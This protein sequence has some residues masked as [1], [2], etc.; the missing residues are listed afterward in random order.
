MIRRLASVMALLLVATWSAPADGVVDCSAPALKEIRES[1]NQ[2]L[3]AARSIRSNALV[4]LLAANI[5]N[6]EAILA[7]K[8]RARNTTGMAVA[9]T[10]RSIFAGA[11]SNLSVT[12]KVDVPAKVRRELVPAVEEFKTAAQRIEDEFERAKSEI[13]QQHLARYQSLTG[14]AKPDA[15]GGLQDF[16]DWVGGKQ[17]TVPAESAGTPVPA[18]TAPPVMLATRGEARQWVTVGRWQGSVGTMDVIPVP[19]GSLQVGTNRQE[20]ANPIAQSVARVEYQG[21]HAIPADFPGPLRLKAVPGLE[22]V[23][24]VEWPAT[25]NDFT[26]SIRLAAASYPSKH[27]FDL[28]AG[29]PEGGAGV[30][31]AGAAMETTSGEAMAAAPVML[32]LNTLPEGASVMLDGIPVKEA[33]TPCHIAVPAGIHTVELAL[34][35]YQKLVLANQEFVTNRVMKLKFEPDPRVVSKSCEISAGVNQWYPSGLLV[36]P[37]SLLVIKAEG[38]WSCG[39]KGERC[40][41]SGYTTAVPTYRHY[42]D[43]ALRQVAAANYGALL[44]RIGKDGAPFVVGPGTRVK[45]EAKGLLYFDVNEVTGRV[46][47]ADNTGTLLIRISVIPPEAQ[48]PAP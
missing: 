43:P 22:G 33:R 21:L 46:A 37:E 42:A 7:E 4:S 27:A 8:T 17:E 34:P 23:E 12:G 28:Q 47:R 3:D 41:P 24:V 44:G 39:A 45:A 20:I 10:E 2:G 29:V 40:P 5:R 32:G 14:Q 36:P 25:R 13:Q 11:L 15:G 26:L 35:A 1:Y 31:F 30:L 48:V 16:L 18:G 9:N 6:A 38:I 19:L